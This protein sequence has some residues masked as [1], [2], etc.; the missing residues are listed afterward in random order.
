[1]GRVEVL[2]R[3]LAA[4]AT[5]EAEDRSGHRPLHYAAEN[6]NV[7]VLERLLAAKATVEAEDGFRRRP[8]HYAAKN[9]RVEV[10]ERLLAAKATVE[11][12]DRSGKTPFDLAKEK[13][14][15]KVMGVLRPVRV[16]LLS[17]DAVPCDPQPDR[18]VRDLREE[19]QKKLKL[20]DTEIQLIAS[21]GEKLRDEQT[22]GEARVSYSGSLTAEIVA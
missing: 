6:G 12:E 13:G 20:Q 14:K 17:G 18:T 7:E 2:E 3:L 8:L 11:A 22:L 21:A 1:M 16:L 9:G 5:V 4:K 10:L 19:V 15:E